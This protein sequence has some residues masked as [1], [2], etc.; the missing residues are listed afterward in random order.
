[1]FELLTR[2]RANYLWP[3]MWA[4]MFYVD[5]PMNG[6]LAEKYGIV[7]GTSHQEP[8]ARSTPNEWNIENPLL[9]AWNF[10]T[11]SQN[12]TKWWTESVQRS[13][14]FETVYTIGM[15]G[16]GDCK[17]LNPIFLVPRTRV[18]IYVS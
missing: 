10:T 14:S 12:L 1:M 3:A 16:T 11:N 6:A 2:L 13:K 4:G 15:R 18:V 7:M 8:M 5:D 17:I 9:G